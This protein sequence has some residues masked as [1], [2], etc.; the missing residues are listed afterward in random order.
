[1]T[2]YIPQR[3]HG[4]FRWWYEYSGGKMT[5]WGAH[6]N[7]IAQWGLGMDDTGPVTIEGKATFPTKGLFN[8][9]MSFSVDYTYATGQRVTCS[10]TGRGV[11][12]MGSDGMVHVDRGFLQTDPADLRD[13]PMGPGDVHLPGARGIR[14]TGSIASGPASARSATWRS[15]RVPSRS[16]T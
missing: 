5:D 10:N 1:M 13:E 14:R 2:P 7:D 3:C 9:A 11:Q 6:H 4:S 16:A 15:A 8:T 12:F